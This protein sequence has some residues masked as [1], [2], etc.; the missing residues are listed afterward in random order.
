MG[1]NAAADRRCRTGVYADGAPTSWYQ[2]RVSEV[3]GL[4]KTNL[5]TGLS[6]AEAQ[7]RQRDCGPNELVE[8]PSAAWWVELLRQFNQLVIWILIA[9][10]ILSAVLGD[11]LEA[12]AIFAIV[13]LNALLGFFQEQKAEKALSSLRKLSSPTAKVFA[14]ARCATSWQRNWFSETSLNWKQATAFRPTCAW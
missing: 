6:A 3:V 10:T 8:G 5:S 7:R 11:W 14:T 12:G 2:R 9:A 13:L 1:A 4:L